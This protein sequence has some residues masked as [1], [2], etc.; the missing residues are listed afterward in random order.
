MKYKFLILVMVGVLLVSCALPDSISSLLD[1]L[2]QPAATA[3]ESNSLLDLVES[4]KVNVVSIRGNI[5]LS[6]LTG[7]TIDLELYNTTEQTLEVEIPC[8]LVFISDVENTSRMMVV[9]RSVITLTKGRN[10]IIKPFVLSVDALKKLPSSD[11]T[12]RVEYL[13][14]G[15]PLD[16]ANCLCNTDLPAETETNELISLQ[17]AAWMAGSDQL[18]SEIPENIK[19]MIVEITGLPISL[20]GLDNTIQELAKTVLPNANAWLERCAITIGN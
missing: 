7:R 20:P 1:R 14:R 12:Y 2:R 13:E 5:G 19:E 4:G 15:K 18:V 6:A 10:K 3:T 17:L 8:G 9:Q 16:F 11:I